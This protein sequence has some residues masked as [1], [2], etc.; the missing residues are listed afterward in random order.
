MTYRLILGDRIH[1]S[2]SLRGWL[3]AKLS[4]AEFDS[5]F[6]SFA[7]APVSEQLAPLAPACT[8]PLLVTSDGIAIDDSLAITEELATRHPDSAIWPKDPKA[9]AVARTLVA[10]MHSG[11]MTLRNDCPMDLARAY[12]GVEISDALQKDLI[13]LQS[14]FAWARKTTGSDDGWLCGAYSAADA[15]YAPVAARIAGFD[16]PVDDATKQYVQLHLN[17]QNFRQWRAIGLATDTPLERYGQTWSRRDWPQADD[18]ADL[19]SA[20]KTCLGEP[21]NAH[22]PYSGKTATWL[23][24]IDGRVFGMCNQICRDKTVADPAAWPAFMDLYHS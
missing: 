3:V 7:E 2:W 11:F 22:C 23:M 10:K 13:Q 16:L 19:P 5:E 15:F 1:S 24:E 21:L 14:L 18:L 4:G 9:R 17:D 6:L 12:S 8:V 20:R